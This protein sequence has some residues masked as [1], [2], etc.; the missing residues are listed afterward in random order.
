MVSDMGPGPTGTSAGTCPHPEVIT[1]LQVAPSKTDTVFAPAF[2][3]STALP[4]VTY[5]VC[6]RGFIANSEG[7]GPTGADPTRAR[8]K[9]VSVDPARPESARTPHPR[10]GVLP[11]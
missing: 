5:I 2:A 6:V 7:P 11:P 9:S 3:P 8:P 4:F 1:A 10:S